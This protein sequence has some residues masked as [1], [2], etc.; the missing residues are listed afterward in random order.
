MPAAW[1][2]AAAVLCG[3]AWADGPEEWAAL[4]NGR[5]AG[6]VDRDPAQ[7]ISVY[8]AVL[9]YLDEDDPLRGELRY[10]RGRARLDLGQRDGAIE[11]L[12]AAAEDARLG[13][14]ARTFLGRL[15]LTESTV[16]SLPFTQDFDD[17]ERSFVRGWPNGRRDDLSV[18]RLSDRPGQVLAWR[19]NVREAE[20]DSILLA[21]A[22]DS[23]PEQL[24][25]T[26]RA[27]AFD[28][29]LRILLEDVEGRRW[30]AP[31]LVIPSDD[32]LSVELGVASFVPAEAPASRARPSG[33]AIR[34]IEIRDVTAF[35]TADRGEN[36]LFFD[37]AECHGVWD[38]QCSWRRAWRGLGAPMRI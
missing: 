2:A 18:V 9:A 33:A 15:E 14:E 19:R 22:V 27:D 16:K 13:P 11:D 8:D 23:A 24:R 35:H 26:A 36:R 7:A 20:S 28:A 37:D 38:P 4:Y 1:L 21:F 17:G 6:A 34:R 12:Q 32:W 3:A 25:I 31:V 30:T 5:L 29:R 10:W